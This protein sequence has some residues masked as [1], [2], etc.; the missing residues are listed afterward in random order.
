[1]GWETYKPNASDIGRIMV[2]KGY[3]VER[4]KIP[5]YLSG[6]NGARLGFY[7]RYKAFGWPFSGGWAEQPAYLVD[8]IE[9]LEIESQKKK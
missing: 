9:R 4:A 1:V 8:V 6:D 5:E 7:S 3:A 2:L